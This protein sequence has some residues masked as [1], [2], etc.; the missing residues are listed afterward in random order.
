MSTIVVEELKKKLSELDTGIV[1]LKGELA[2]V[3][4]QRQAFVKVIAAYDPTYVDETTRQPLSGR[5]PPRRATALLKGHDLR[6]GLLET[7]R[8]S[9]EPILVA[10]L[11]ER[12][13][14]T[15][16]FAGAIDEIAPRLSL[17]FSTLLHKLEQVGLVR[18]GDAEDRR[19]RLWEIAR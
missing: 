7:L 3:E 10:D 8:D 1:K 18:S 13:L 19:R 4:D 6:R 9:Q 15:N 14:K 5:A 2:T 16:G 12:Y 11:S 17:R